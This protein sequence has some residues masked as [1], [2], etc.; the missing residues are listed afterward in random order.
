[1]E[2]QLRDIIEGVSNTRGKDFFSAITLKLAEVIDAEF[3]FVA[4]L[5]TQ[6]YVSRTIALVAAGELVDN[7]E[8]SLQYTPCANVADNAV[9][10]YPNNV[11][12]LFPKDQLLIDMNIEAYLGT[13]LIGSKGDVIGIIVALY[14][15]PIEQAAHTQTL[16]EIFSGRIAA[17]LERVKYEQQLLEV[18]STLEQKVLK[19]TSDFNET[20][21]QLQLTQTQLMESEKIA[22]LGNLVASV[23]HEVNTPLGVAITG[24]SLLQDAFNELIERFDS[25]QLTVDSMNE[26]K[27]LYREALPLVA[28]NL[29]RAKTLINNFKSVENNFFWFV[30]FRK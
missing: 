12:Q 3:T 30:T 2:Q 10:M 26:F 18:N 29:Q 7:I 11:T 27:G 9:C 16:F 4:E 21:E 22:A 8:Y 19:R 15:K 20:L 1:M 14:A 6:A 17:E 28:D 13:P 25:K 23:A 5:D 24:Q